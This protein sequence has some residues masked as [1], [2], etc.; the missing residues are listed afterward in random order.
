MIFRERWESKPT[1]NLNKNTHSMRWLNSI[2]QLAAEVKSIFLF[3]FA[4]KQERGERDG[5]DTRV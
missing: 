3:F 4:Q 1:L 2:S 5:W